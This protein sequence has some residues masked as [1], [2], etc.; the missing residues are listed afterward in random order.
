MFYI[1][2]LPAHAS[3]AIAQNC[4]IFVNNKTYSNSTIDN[5]SPSEPL[6]VRIY[7]SVTQDEKQVIN[8]KMS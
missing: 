3:W 2:H 1:F 8:C 7:F 6:D 5:L 4:Y